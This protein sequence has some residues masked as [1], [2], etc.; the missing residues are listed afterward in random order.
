MEQP[1][2]TE[3]THHSVELKAQVLSAN[4][5]R[6]AIRRDNTA[7]EVLLQDGFGL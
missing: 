6:V 4:D 7:V 5:I 2:G 3:A 1:R